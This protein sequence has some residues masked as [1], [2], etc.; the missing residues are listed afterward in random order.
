MFG[1]FKS[2]EK[3]EKEEK[4]KKIEEVKKWFLPLTVFRKPQGIKPETL[5]KFY[6][7][8]E[9]RVNNH[10]ESLHIFG[11]E[12]VKS[13]RKIFV[14]CIADIGE[15]YDTIDDRRK[16]ID[17]K[18]KFINGCINKFK[19]EKK[20]PES[21]ENQQGIPESEENQKGILDSEQQ[22][23][24]EKLNEMNKKDFVLLFAEIMPELIE[25][26][27][28]QFKKAMNELDRESERW[29]RENKIKQDTIRKDQMELATG[30]PSKDKQGT[31][32][33]KLQ[34]SIHDKHMKEWY[35]N[36]DY[37]VSGRGWGGSKKKSYK[38]AM[39]RTRHSR[40]SRRTR[41]SHRSRRNDTRKYKKYNKR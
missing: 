17:Y 31:D 11:D 28:E 14:D 15:S 39:R 1:L 3:I 16:L 38:R 27:D 13:W 25:A 36:N 21:E 26:R 34:E 2:K 6:K 20:I 32:S 40:H 10:L 9:A 19:D 24:E 29:L 30:S 35:K 18:E 4:E 41:R 33:K 37:S 23:V 5:D 12:K 22:Q 7:D 8:S